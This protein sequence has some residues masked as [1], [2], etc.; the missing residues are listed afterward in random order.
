VA[1]PA[2][3]IELPRSGPVSSRSGVRWSVLAAISV[4]AFMTGLDG[5]IVATI[6]PVI[7]RAFQSDAGAVE[8]VV[9]SYLLVLTTLMLSFGR[10]GDLRGHRAV[11]LWGF[12]VFVG[13]SALAGL[14]PSLGAL[15]A[16]RSMQGLGAALLSAN[17]PAILT[18]V[19]PP[20]QRGRALGVFATMTYLGLVIGPSVGGWLAEAASWRIVFAVNIPVGAL[21]LLLSYRFVPRGT[22]GARQERFDLPGAA[23]FTLA[24]ALLLL[25]LNQGHTWGWG[26]PAV[27]GSVAAALV[28]LVAF[29]AIE[30]RVPS[31]MLDLSL[32]A[33]RRF[34]AAVGSAILNYIGAFGVLFLL[35]FSLIEGRG[36][37]PSEAGRLLTAMPV[38]MAVVA[39]LSGALSDRIG[40]R[41]PTTLGMGIQ[42]GG[43]L[44][45]S[46]LNEDS[47]L[48]QVTL[49][50]VVV[51]LGIGLFVSPNTNAALG[52]AP[53]ARRGVASAVVGTARNLGMVL[54]LGVSGAIFTTL[55]TQAGPSPTTAALVRAVDVGLLASM[56]LVAL[57]VV[58]SALE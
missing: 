37:S 24:L 21:A 17:S 45:L 47:P 1:N 39:P 23:A 16:A 56:G 27:L 46:R 40:S 15:I 7:G 22:G 18:A 2:L 50:L 54:G 53:V 5:S 26:S 35:P 48:D 51:G 13:G 25:G 10:L 43:L 28:L 38:V 3:P 11:Y 58:S 19:F 52:S 34:S 12:V 32:F 49:G 30:R 31:P 8:W 6:L 33:R 36:L 4:G 20:E 29:I 55:L 44:L 41:L 14:A 9:T 57:G 42:A